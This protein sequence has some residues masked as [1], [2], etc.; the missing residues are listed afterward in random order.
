MKLRK[1]ICAALL[2][3]LLLGLW[4]CAFSQE[5]RNYQLGQNAL[6]DGRLADAA[7]YF[8]GLAD[9]RDSAAQLQ[10]IYAR[11]LDLYDAGAY[12]EAAEVFLALDRYEV[13]DAADY[14]A[15]SL[16]LACLDDRDGP[17]ARAALAD[18]D[19]AS[20]PVRDALATADRLLF[21]GTSVFRPEYVA[22]ELV[23]GEL[24]AQIREITDDP[25]SRRYLYA[26]ERQEADRLY[27][28]YREY[29]MAAFPQSFRDESDRY[30]SFLA[31]GITCYVSNFHSVD[32]GVVIL[33]PQG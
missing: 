9:Y 21:P 5:A 25:M 32:G 18:G 12:P 6:D 8:G 33:I 28:Q 7:G 16:A 27:Q 19:T 11:A 13:G 15:A 30:F 22:R 23:S 31:D 20:A 4:G 1:I 14:A 26:M 17:G 3:A 10:D 2:S 24:A 29:C